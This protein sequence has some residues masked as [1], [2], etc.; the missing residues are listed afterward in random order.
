MKPALPC[1][2]VLP[3]LAALALGAT[4]CAVAAGP[5]V[6]SAAYPQPT[7]AD[8]TRTFPFSMIGQ[9]H[10]A[11]GNSWFSGSGTVVRPRSVLTAAHNLWDANG[12][13]STDILFRRGL[14]GRSDLSEQYASRIYV[15]SGYRENTRQFSNS[16]PRAFSYD[17]G[18]LV[19]RAPVAGGS[20]AGWWANPALLTGHAPL[21]ALG[22]G[23]EFHTG[24]D[25]LS[26][27]PAAPFTPVVG[28]FWD[29]LSIYAES[30]MSG[31]PVF[32]RD[33]DGKLYLTGIVVAGSNEPPSTGIRILD[34]VAADFIRRYLK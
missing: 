27:A 7:G 16:D 15:L 9:V 29:N 17:T 6:V 10:F 3:C 32:A 4:P 33:S 12:G 20:T 2:A 28:A 22:Y 24:D 34:Q 19:F 26:V 31:G 8:F 18:G 1:L 13:F 25:L 21:L 11:N 23:G 5:P 30:G 14:A